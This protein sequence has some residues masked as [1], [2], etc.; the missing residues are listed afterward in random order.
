MSTSSR[1][2][3]LIPLAA[4]AALI[5]A[6]SFAVASPKLDG[7]LDQ[8]RE[9][10]LDAVHQGASAIAEKTDARPQERSLQKKVR[11]DRPIPRTGPP[12]RPAQAEPPRASSMPVRSLDGQ[13]VPD[14]VA[15]RDDAEDKRHSGRLPPR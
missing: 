15:L 13:S 7:T 9:L 4:L 8:A 11:R 14:F 2:L 10:A 1:A 5:A 3:G 6:G 12:P